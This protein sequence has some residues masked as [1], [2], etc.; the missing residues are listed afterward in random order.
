MKG[1]HNMQNLNKY[2]AYKNIAD[3]YN[4]ALDLVRDKRPVLGEPVV[5]PYYSPDVDD[6]NKRI[7]ILFAV[8]S[9]NGEFA[10]FDPKEYQ[11]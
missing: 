11:S 7:S 9:L 4:Q 10:V 2:K 1:Y 3:N 8:G 6:P 5:V